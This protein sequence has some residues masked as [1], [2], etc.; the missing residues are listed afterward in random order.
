MIKPPIPFHNSRVDLLSYTTEVLLSPQ[1]RHPDISKHMKSLASRL[2]ACNNTLALIM[3]EHLHGEFDA[4][5]TT[6][7][8]KNISKETQDAVAHTFK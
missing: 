6:L 4:A 1:E 3:Q 2:A 7:N 5:I 8:Q